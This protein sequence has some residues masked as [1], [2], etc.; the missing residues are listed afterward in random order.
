MRGRRGG[1]TAGSTE[2]ASPGPFQPPS[3]EP[4]GFVTHMIHPFCRRESPRMEVGE[5]EVWW[6]AQQGQAKSLFTRAP[7]RGPF[8]NPGVDFPHV[9]LFSALE[10]SSPTFL[11]LAKRGQL[12][13]QTLET[14]PK[15]Q[16]AGPLLPE[17]LAR[18][19]PLKRQEAPG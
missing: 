8:W 2:V 18:P 12:P 13:G 14:C 11:P 17:T 16:N 6:E 4:F 3:Q 7:T 10:A 15:V 9:F 1:E 5:R 19:Y